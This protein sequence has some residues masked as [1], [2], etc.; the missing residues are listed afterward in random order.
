MRAVLVRLRSWLQRVWGTK[1][2]VTPLQLDD[3]CEAV[4]DQGDGTEFETAVLNMGKTMRELRQESENY[5]ETV[6]AVGD[7]TEK[8]KSVTSYL[9]EKLVTDDEDQAADKK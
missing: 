2:G 5:A 7:N 1:S 4:F 9:L 6:E 3:P 8:F